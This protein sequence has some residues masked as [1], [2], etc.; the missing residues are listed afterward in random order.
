MHFYVTDLKHSNLNKIEGGQKCIKD[1]VKCWCS[2]FQNNLSQFSKFRNIYYILK[3]VWAV[4]SSGQLW[5]GTF[6]KLS[7]P[8]CLSF[9]D[10]LVTDGVR[11][12]K[13][14]L[15]CL[16]NLLKTSINFDIYLFPWV[17]VLQYHVSCVWWKVGG[18]MKILRILWNRFLY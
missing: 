5:L 13:M 7:Y 14:F 8:N 1:K 16:E 12:L 17:R 2:C 11:V 4:L 6:T 15:N 10:V 9:D 3:S 18:G